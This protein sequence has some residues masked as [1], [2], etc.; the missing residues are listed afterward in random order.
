MVNY[1]IAHIIMNTNYF[2]FHRCRKGDTSF[3]KRT[4]SVLSE[5]THIFKDW[6]PNQ[7]TKKFARTENYERNRTENISPRV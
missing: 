4:R 7:M 5:K 1:P 6:Q 2:H 3:L